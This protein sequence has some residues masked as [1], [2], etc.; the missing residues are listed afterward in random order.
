MKKACIREAVHN[1]NRQSD[2]CLL[3]IL[4]YIKLKILL[5]NFQLHVA[6][7]APLSLPFLLLKPLN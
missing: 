3:L 2:N 1:N 4:K 5:L 7:L 6:A